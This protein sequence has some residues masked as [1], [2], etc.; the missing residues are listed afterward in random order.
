M[1]A[2]G[3]NLSYLLIQ[4]FCLFVIPVLILGGVIYWLIKRNSLKQD[5]LVATLTVTDEG[6]VIPK[7]LLPNTQTLEVYQQKDKIILVPKSE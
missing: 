6:V 4:L 2:I 7:K 5:E 1:E 3:I